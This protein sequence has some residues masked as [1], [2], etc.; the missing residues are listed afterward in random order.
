MTKYQE[1]QEKRENLKR[2]VTEASDY[3]YQLSL[4][5]SYDDLLE[6]ILEEFKSLEKNLE[7]RRKIEVREWGDDDMD[8]FE[9]D[10]ERDL[11]NDLMRQKIEESKKRRKPLFGSDREV[12]SISENFDEPIE[13]FE[14]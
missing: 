12:I 10:E 4:L 3:F 7:W 8:C 14:D 11:W 13:D 1:F 5:R 9:S 2:E 6:K